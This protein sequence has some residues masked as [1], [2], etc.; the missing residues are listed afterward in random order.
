MEA[1]LNSTMYQVA[2][3]QSDRCKVVHTKTRTV[4][5]VKRC[6]VNQMILIKQG[7]REKEGKYE[8]TTA[9][10]KVNC[11]GNLSHHQV[12]HRYPTRELLTSNHSGFHCSFKHLHVA[13]SVLIEN[14]YVSST[15]TNSTIE[16]R[17]KIYIKVV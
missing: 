10:R 1:R 7:E 8:L 6:K 17:I 4:V 16:K 14:T 15:L 2:F 3:D 9:E 11:R 13:W 5:V 12:N